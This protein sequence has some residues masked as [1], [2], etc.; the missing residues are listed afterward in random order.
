MTQKKEIWKDVPNY[1]GLYEV[2]NMGRVRSFDKCVVATNG[3]RRFYKGKIVEGYYKDGYRCLALAKNK[4]YKKVK[5]SQVVAMA[6]LNHKPNGCTV[7]VDHING[8]RDDDRL[9]DLRMVT[10]RENTSTCF[11]A[12]RKKLSSQCVGVIQSIMPRMSSS[13]SFHYFENIGLESEFY[14][15]D[16]DLIHARKFPY[17]SLLIIKPL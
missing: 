14:T 6:F 12:D 13:H 9:E 15:S 7:V 2:S 17:F 10:H 1:E 5:H 4:R 11:R 8:I 16:I 3:A